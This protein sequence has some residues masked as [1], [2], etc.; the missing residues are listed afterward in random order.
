MRFLTLWLNDVIREN[1]R[2]KFRSKMLSRLFWFL[3]SYLLC[4][5]LLHGKE[6]LPVSN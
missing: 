4:A 5:K 2:Q 1:E 3:A 6:K